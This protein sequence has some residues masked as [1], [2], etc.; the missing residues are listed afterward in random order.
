MEACRAS[1]MPHDLCE[2]HR[3]VALDNDNYI[4]F[5]SLASVFSWMA[6]DCTDP[7]LCGRWAWLAGP[8]LLNFEPPSAPHRGWRTPTPTAAGSSHCQGHELY[9]SSPPLFPFH[10]PDTYTDTTNKQPHTETNTNTWLKINQN[11]TI[12]CLSIILH[13][14]VYFWVWLIRNRLR[15]NPFEISVTIS[16]SATRV[17]AANKVLTRIALLL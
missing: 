15:N 9:A 1:V 2:R 16:N 8:R 13:N 10:Q 6:S 5:Q 14:S 7:C 17:P 12:I 11:Q 4:N 3:G